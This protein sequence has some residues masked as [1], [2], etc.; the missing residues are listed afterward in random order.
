MTERLQNTANQYIG[1]AKETIGQTLGYPDMA[2]DGAR[3]KTQAETAQKVADAKANAER[4]QH[5]AENS[6]NSVV[7]GAKQVV[8]QTLGLPGMAA[9][10]AAQKSNADTQQK[11]EDARAH[12]HGV[13]N[14][15]EGKIKQKVG[16]LT[17]DHSMK[18][19]GAA[20]ETQGTLQ[21]NI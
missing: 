1:A 2:A 20:T 9:E 3:Q 6:A 19:D 12:V 10:G 14:E 18:V 8:G 7:G 13:G 16:D 11:V 17:N 15:I 5:T 21:R 4:L